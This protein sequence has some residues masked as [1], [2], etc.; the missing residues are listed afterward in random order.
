MNKPEI[1]A[2]VLKTLRACGK[3]LALP[4]PIKKIVREGFPNV[5]LISFS[6]QMKRR[7]ISYEEMK[8]LYGTADACTDYYADSDTYIIYY[9]DVDE[10][11]MSSNRYRW[12]IAHEL[13]HIALEHHIKY[14]QSRI[15]RSGITNELYAIIEDEA[16]MFAAYILVPHIVISCVS[17]RHHIG[18]GKLCRVSGAAAVRRYD[19]IQAWSRRGTAEQYDMDILECFSHYVEK[20]AYSKS[21]KHWLNSHRA[22]KKCSSQVESRF[23]EFCEVCGSSIKGHYKMKDDIVRY[24]GIELDAQDRAVECPVCHNTAVPE[25]GN[26]CIICGN[27]IVN[28]C[29]EAPD[30]FASSCGNTEPLPGHAR[31]CPFC[32]NKSTFFKRGLL[33]E[34]SVPAFDSP[35]E[36]DSELPF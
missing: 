22:C 9:N 27:Q 23:T 25:A 31:Y 2:A 34:W 4:V 36:E 6:K 20:N 8:R 14:K 18:I 19:A 35:P 7:N 12:N 33:T 24:S 13:G 15:F 5:R 11:T 26:F 3:P 32:G 30:P 16:N 17:D 29:S 10:L 21:A 28:L 1:K